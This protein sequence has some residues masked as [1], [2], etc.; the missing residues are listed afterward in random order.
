MAQSARPYKDS[1]ESALTVDEDC[2]PPV[3]SLRQIVLNLTTSSALNVY[4]RLRPRVGGKPFS[5]PAI[6]PRSD[7]TVETTTATAEHQQQKRFSFTKVFTELTG[8]SQVFEEAMRS[9][10][11]AFVEGKNVLLFAYGPTASG[12]T[13]TMQGPLKDPG[14][15]PRTLDRLF[16]LLG[17]QVCKG[18]PVRPDCFE[19]VVPL[20]SEEEAAVL[21]LKQELLAERGARSAADFSTFHLPPG[22]DSQDSLLASRFSDESSTS[23]GL[24]VMVWLSFYEIYNEGLYDLLVS[25]APA[26]KKVR[27]GRRTLLKLGEDR[28]KRS[29]VRGLVEVPVHNADEAHRL[30]CLARHNQSIA[31]TS[32]N[33]SSSRSHCVFTV[34]LVCSVGGEW[35]VSTLM[36]CDLAGSERPSKTGAGGPR[37]REAGR[38]NTSLM[39]LSR[40]LEGLR[41]NRDSS[42]KKAPVPFRESKLTQVMQAY[43]TTGGHVSLVV[44]ISP[45][46]SMLEES[47][48]ALKFSAVAC[49]VVPLQLETRHERCHRAVR[50]LTKVWQRTSRGDG[51][52]DPDQVS[53]SSTSADDDYD[54]APMDAADVEELFD[55]VSA[56]QLELASTQERL[57]HCERMANAYQAKCGEYEEMV[58]ALEQTKRML[59][60]NADREMSVRVRSACEITRLEM[61]RQ[62][63]AGSVMELLGRCEE[64][65]RRLAELQK[66]LDERPAHGEALHRPTSTVNQGVQTEAA[67]SKCPH[68]EG[69]NSLPCK[70]TDGAE[71]RS[72][73]PLQEQLSREVDLRR[74]AEDASQEALSQLASTSQEL[75]AALASKEELEQRLADAQQVISEVHG[76]ELED[77]RSTIAQRDRELEK[78]RRLCE[79]SAKAAEEA[80]AQ[81]SALREDFEKQMEEDVGMAVFLQ[82]NG[83]ALE[84]DEE[85]ARKEADE[86]KEALQEVQARL[87]L[88]EAELGACREEL[89]ES[90]EAHRVALLQLESTQ[91]ELAQLKNSRQ[92]QSEQSAAVDENCPPRTRR[93]TRATRARRTQAAAASSEA[94]DDDDDDDDDDFELPHRTA[95]L[96]K[97][98]ATVPDEAHETA[99]G[100]RNILGE[101][102][103]ESSPPPL[104]SDMV[105]RAYARFP[106]PSAV[107]QR[108]PRLLSTDKMD[109]VELDDDDED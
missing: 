42:A 48:N 102:N 8:Q 78:L 17:S 94:F 32:L 100:R 66:L 97:K 107:G 56:L 35:R 82:E 40:C 45:S 86:A 77:L 71:H 15:V 52:P 30:L 29:F 6:K 57:K 34:R 76:G 93:T 12:K 103:A 1:A 70:D 106:K 68:C 7:T 14:I 28:S 95:R 104:I 55:T 98:S 10:L 74:H 39:V 105:S 61:Y 3:D 83:R 85:E 90:K 101:S 67:S 54:D 59:R 25:A 16:K 63:E 75:A 108:K 60:E 11:D 46:L 73:E 22:G 26:N 87:G 65:E 27:G 31:E 41:H 13:H 4:V 69:A 88:V 96:P 80:E 23:S 38:I 20:N 44:N 5:N 51:R 79:D 36:L 92:A 109:F 37:L 64:N 47:L 91:K 21:A 53:P 9:P 33:R 49:E 24:E 62:A 2:L 43:F 81:V 89:S 72:L 18:A 50:R 84:L 58:T 99:T 19:D